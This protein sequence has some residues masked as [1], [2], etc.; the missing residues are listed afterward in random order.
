MNLALQLVLLFIGVGGAIVTA[1]TLPNSR[2]KWIWVTAFAMAGITGVILTVLTYGQALSNIAVSASQFAEK[3]FGYLVGAVE[4]KWFQVGLAFIV[5]FALGIVGPREYRRWTRAW[6][7]QYQIFTLGDRASLM[8][9]GEL[10]E[11]IG[12]LE[13]EIDG[14][15]AETLK[16][17]PKRPFGYDAI[18]VEAPKSP[19]L[20]LIERRR[21]RAVAELIELRK[22]QDALNIVIV[23]SIYDQLQRGALIA[24][25]FR[26]PVGLRAKEIY[27]PAAQWRFLRFDGDFS[28]ASGK[29]MAYTAVLVTR[30]LWN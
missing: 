7:S 22:R 13:K 19:V 18:P 26:D 4:L 9:F 10:G 24:K 27:I 30:R 3:V 6:C 8:E 15:H 29:G 17:T 28:A 1:L 11:K 20:D 23:N 5:G 12:A 16:N 2:A 14:L 21:S 25:G